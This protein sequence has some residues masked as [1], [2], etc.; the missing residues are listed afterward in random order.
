M[1]RD[2][3]A[4]HAG[5][6]VDKDTNS[7]CV[8]LYQTSAFTFDSPEHASS[9]FKLETPG[10]IYTRLMNPTTDVL[11]KRLSAMDGALCGV[12]VASGQAAITMAVMNI[13]QVGQNLVSSPAIYG[14]TSNLF[15]NT[16]KRMGIDIHWADMNDLATIE[17][18]IDENT[19]LIYCETIGNPKNEVPDFEKIAEIAHRHGIPFVVDN[20][21]APSG[22]NPFL[23]GADIVV[24]SMTKYI[25]GHGTSMG[26]MILDSGKFD[27]TGKKYGTVGKFPEFTE[28][29]PSY[30][31]MIF[32]DH[33]GG[34]SQKDEN[35]NVLN[36]CFNARIRTCLLRDM[37]PCLSP[38]NSWLFIQG[39]ETL[40][41]RWKRICETSLKLAQW[42]EQNPYVTW[43]NYP[44]LP[45]HPSHA[46][47][48]KYLDG[49]GGII[50]FGIQG[51]IESGKRF[52]QNVK[53]L[54]HVT[55]I[56]DSHSLVAHPAST[57]HQQ[58]SEEELAACGITHD[59]I[60]IAVGLEDA[61]DLIA[62]L[63]Q[64][65]KASV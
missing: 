33:F 57:T 59:F 37:G 36:P 6:Q 42:L 47:A 43:V 31:G 3:L 61:D 64:A 38:F 8:P 23:Y 55:N 7:R 45:S 40:S 9:L 12:A 14:G 50:G 27:W 44:G 21:C 29:D 62:D 22:C 16:V 18:G 5:H 58:L 60:R 19:R 63:E 54:S 10:N 52:L 15:H 48:V 4:V 17:A 32:Y 25:G 26:G 1:H 56:G 51:G 11:E 13:T 30:H 35:G 28:P 53:L 2:T 65:L 34:D 39:V 49:F 46:N 41:L 20:T 24:Y